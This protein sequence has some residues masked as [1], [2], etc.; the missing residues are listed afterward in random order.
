MKRKE[1]KPP[2]DLKSRERLRAFLNQYQRADKG[3]QRLKE[4]GNLMGLSNARSKPDSFAAELAARIAAR[5][6]KLSEI[7]FSVL[8]VIDLLPDDSIAKD[9][10]EMRHLKGMGWKEISG[11]AY[12]CV[13][14]CHEHYDEALDSLLLHKRVREILDEASDLL[15]DET[16]RP[17]KDLKG[18]EELRTFLNQYRQADK[19]IQRLE[20][21][22][23]MLGL[24]N[25][26]MEPG[27][28]AAELAAR[29]A[30]RREK[31]YKIAMS[32]LDAVDFLPD[33]SVAKDIVEMRHL[34]G[35]EW[36][37]ITEILHLSAT[38]CQEYYAR[39][40]DRLLGYEGVRKLLEEASDSAT[41]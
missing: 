34:K 16:S 4:R 6:K 19:G 27:S 36:N 25:V 32:V 13:A 39:A 7:A 40:L 12:R 23:D 28:F 38:A 26:R 17:R 14:M 9:I 33:D 5:Q 31:L 15:D 11:A 41:N 35:M 10:V 37:E 8:D 1:P 21:R 30:A 2:K 29:V 22:R 20:K 18:R 24:S 3:L